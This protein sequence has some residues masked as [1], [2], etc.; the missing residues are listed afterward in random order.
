MF[1]RRPPATPFPYFAIPRVAD[2]TRAPL[3][4]A[5]MTD[6]PRQPDRFDAFALVASRG[7]IEG[8]VDPF[9]LERV[10]D[11][12]G[13]EN[14]EIPPAEVA[15]VLEGDVDG[16]GR[17]VLNVALDG[18]VPLQCQRCLRLFTFPVHQRTTLLLAHD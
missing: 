15:Y 14:G 10:Q 18:E 6:A 7:R 16:M 4:P 2:T 17:S 1:G 9:D 12:L 3:A 5:T 11:A 8:I 13:D